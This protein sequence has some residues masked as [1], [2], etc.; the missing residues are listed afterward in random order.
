VGA[1]YDGTASPRAIVYEAGADWGFSYF[2][3]LFTHDGRIVQYRAAEDGVDLVRIGGDQT[4]ARDLRQEVAGFQNI[5]L[6]NTKLRTFRDLRECQNKSSS[7]PNFD[8]GRIESTLLAG[9]RWK[10]AKVL[11][12][13]GI[14]DTEIKIM[15]RVDTNP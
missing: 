9:G 14:Y 8:Q 4:T 12:N 1:A 11:R 15:E 7:C 5:L 10:E 13:F 6:V 3:L 2:P